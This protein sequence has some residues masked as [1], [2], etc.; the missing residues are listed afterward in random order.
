[1]TIRVRPASES[2][3]PALLDLYVEL[4]PSDE[5]LSAE[6]ALDVW[7]TIE[8]Q[9]GRTVLV[10]ETATT[11]VGTLDCVVLPNLT[12]RAR[13]FAL[14]ENV[15]VTAGHRRSGIGSTLLHAAVDLARQ[16]GCYK[17]QL[18]SRDTRHG[19]HVFYEAVGFRPVAQGYRRY[20]D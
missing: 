7:R 10:A 1:M 19:A 6:I 20:L 17:V 18:L 8:E 11:V 12:R 5:P 15:V 4:H 14:V 16:A 3:L 2:D 9:P 13:P